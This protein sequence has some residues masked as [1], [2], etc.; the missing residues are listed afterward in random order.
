MIAVSNEN[1]T[2]G[3]FSGGNPFLEDNA[4]KISQHFSQLNSDLTEQGDVASFIDE[5][6]Y[7]MAEALVKEFYYVYLYYP[8]TKTWKFSN[9]KTA[10]YIDA[11]NRKQ[12]HGLRPPCW[13]FSVRAISKT[14]ALTQAKRWLKR[15]RLE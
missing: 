5:F 2:D 13:E 8:E 9:V 3:V 10:Y 15:N 11:I 12:L 14:H 7:L 1:L 6:D 4:D